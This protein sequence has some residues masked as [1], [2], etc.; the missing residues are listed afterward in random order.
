MSKHQD[1]EDYILTPL[2]GEPSTERVVLSNKEDD[3]PDV[4]VFWDPVPTRE[5]LRKTTKSVCELTLF[6]RITQSHWLVC[7]IV[8]AG[9]AVA[10]YWGF[11]GG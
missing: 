9:I 6:G 11:F 5:S 8:G 4:E 1:D 3:N 2:D 10:I 7:Y